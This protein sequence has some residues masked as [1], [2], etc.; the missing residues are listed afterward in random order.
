MPAP[1]IGDDCTGIQR[2]R[3]YHFVRLLPRVALGVV[4]DLRP[5]A[6]IAE[7]V[8]V[9]VRRLRGSAFREQSR[10]EQRK[11]SNEGT[12]IHCISR[13]IGRQR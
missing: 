4:E 10:A 3:L 1:I 13:E 6:G 9:R 8:L 5:L 11:R 2:E 7:A 12:S